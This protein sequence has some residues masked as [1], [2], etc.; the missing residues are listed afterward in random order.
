MISGDSGAYASIREPAVMSYKCRRK[1]ISFTYL[2]FLRR[3]RLGFKTQD[4]E[5][6]TDVSLHVIKGSSGWW[7]ERK[8]GDA[9]ENMSYEKQHAS[10]FLLY[11]TPH[12]QSG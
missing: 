5:L 1:H 7:R 2:C 6:E 11:T 8:P 12:P 10:C 3:D 4:S 9:N